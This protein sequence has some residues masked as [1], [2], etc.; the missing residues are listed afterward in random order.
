MVNI[1]SFENVT[2]DFPHADELIEIVRI[3]D[4]GLSNILNT[5]KAVCE[6][7]RETGGVRITIDYTAGRDAVIAIFDPKSN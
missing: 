6:K 2:T 5:V 7:T 4:K 3:K 1:D